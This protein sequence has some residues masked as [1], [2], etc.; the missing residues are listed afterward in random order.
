[1][2]ADEDVYVEALVRGADG[3]THRVRRE[4]LCDFGA[5]SECESRLNVA[6]M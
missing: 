1:M 3:V 6:T 2:A 4:L 5:G